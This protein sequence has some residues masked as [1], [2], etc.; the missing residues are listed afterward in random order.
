LATF[1]EYAATDRVTAIEWHRFAIRHYRDEHME[2]AAGVRSD[3]RWPTQAADGK[4]RAR[5]A[6]FDR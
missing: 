5:T 6:L 2:N 1:I 3:T 4:D